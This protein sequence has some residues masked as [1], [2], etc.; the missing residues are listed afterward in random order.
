MT[1]IEIRAAIRGKV[2]RIVAYSLSVSFS[3]CLIFA[4]SLTG[5]LAGRLAAQSYLTS[6]GSPGFAAPYPAEM[7]SVDAASGNLHLEIPLGT[8]PQRATSAPLV[9]KLI[10][11]SHIWVPSMIRQTRFGR[12]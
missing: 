5:P 12:S 10:Y 4:L 2:S 8:Y 6:T 9:A 3:T 1:G 7:G 11:D